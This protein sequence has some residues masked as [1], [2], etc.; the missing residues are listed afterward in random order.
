MSG[1]SLDYVYSRVQD[2]A[3]QIRNRSQDPMHIAFVN[4]LEKVSK[5]LHDIE[6]VFSCD[7]GDGDEE[8]AIMALGIIQIPLAPMAITPK[9]LPQARGTFKRNAE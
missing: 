4:H 3:M 7:Y 1:G 2:A 9:A 8:K 5:A 6:W